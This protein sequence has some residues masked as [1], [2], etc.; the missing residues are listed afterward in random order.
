M[1]EIDFWLRLEAMTTVK[2]HPT[3]KRPQAM[4]KTKNDIDTHSNTSE[5]VTA[6]QNLP[7][8]IQQATLTQIHYCPN[9]CHKLWFNDSIQVTAFVGPMCQKCQ[10][11][12]HKWMQ[13][14]Y[15]IYSYT[16]IH[17]RLELS[18]D[19]CWIARSRLLSI[20][21]KV[22]CTHSCGRVESFTWLHK[23]QW[24]AREYVLLSAQ[25]VSQ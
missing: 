11:D 25:S 12:N 17:T 19:E 10:L 6:N 13:Y 23:W 14:T 18:G 1:T 15:L 21:R 9:T 22:H 7:T 16:H 4:K 2:D 20:S 3:H 5:T 24:R 8:A